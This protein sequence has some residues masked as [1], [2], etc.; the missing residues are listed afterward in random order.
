MGNSF[1]RAYAWAENR[2]KMIR[3]FALK[4]PK[5]NIIEVKELF[6]SESESFC[7]ALS[8]DGFEME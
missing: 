1:E 4:H 2:E 8:T 3:L 5:A 6:R 7:S